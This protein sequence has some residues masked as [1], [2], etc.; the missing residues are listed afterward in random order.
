MDGVIMAGGRGTR[1]WPLSRNSSPK[2]LLSI[3]GDRSML[4]MTVDRLRKIDFV[5]DIYIVTGRDLESKI[6]HEIEGVPPGNIIVEPSGKN[7]APCIG[8][9]AHH[10]LERGDDP[11]FGVFPS[12]HLIVGHRTFSEALE[13]ARHLALTE[14]SL[15]TIGVNPSFPHTG[16]G[17]IQFD[18]RNELI[19]G[20]AYQVKT[21]AEKPTPSVAKRFLKSGDFLWNSGMFVWK[22]SAYLEAMDSF[23][24]E[25]SEILREVG[26]A[27]GSKDYQSTLDAR[28]EILVPESVDYGIL[29]KAKNI[30]VVKSKF[31]WSDV[32]SWDSYYELLTKNDDGNVIKGDAVVLD[33]QNSL[34]HSNGRLTAVVGLDNIV[35]VNVEDATLIVPRD[36]VEEVK[37]IVELLRKSGRDELL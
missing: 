32:G 4:Q 27:I 18:R 31:E 11:V 30:C 15:V 21:F 7:T 17:Y 20:R 26:D 3:I 22:T 23:M 24:P 12:D 9:V 33:S 35:V 28:W 8:L 13:T 36:R 10:L 5:R 25:Q 14:G 1:F 6:K 2:Q 16:Y 29:E 19:K 37:K 34:I